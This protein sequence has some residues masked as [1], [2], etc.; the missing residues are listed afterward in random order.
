VPTKTIDFDLRDARADA[1]QARKAMNDLRVAIACLLI[2]A[3]LIVRTMTEAG[4]EF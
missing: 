1:Y 2:A 4:S 3:A